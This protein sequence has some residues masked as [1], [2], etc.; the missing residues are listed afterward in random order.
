M[1]DT[2]ALIVKG[3]EGPKVE[4]RG[5]NKADHWRKLDAAMLTM[6]PLTLG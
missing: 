3:S 1:G 2:H 6:S 4:L 5:E